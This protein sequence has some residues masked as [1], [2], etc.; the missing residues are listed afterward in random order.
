MCHEIIDLNFFHD[1]NPFGP[2][3][4]RLEYFRSKFRF[5]RDI[6]SQSC[7]RVCSTPRRLSPRWNA[8]HTIFSKFEA[9]ELTPNLHCRDCPQ[10]VAHHGRLT[11]WRDAHRRDCFRGVQHTV[12]T[13]L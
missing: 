13:T 4:N 9:L 3:I 5:H 6:Q 8:H 11:Q 2:L 10:C 12:E 1:S 7:L